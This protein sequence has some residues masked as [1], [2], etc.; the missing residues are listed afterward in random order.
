MVG[1]R[2]A[3]LTLIQ[4][5]SRILATSQRRRK[6]EDL[7]RVVYRRTA[8]PAAP[9][10]A[11]TVLMRTLPRTRAPAA[12]PVGEELAAAAVAEDDVEPATGADVVD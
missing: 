5:A 2:I 12:P 9:T 10:R 1:N 3:S 8:R 6:I 11:A 4:P 7:D